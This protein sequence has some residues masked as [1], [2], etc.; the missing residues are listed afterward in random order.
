MALVE[1]FCETPSEELLDGCTK[2]QLL[3]I[4]DH[5]SV[6][7]SDKRLKDTVKSILKAK[8]YEMEILPGKMG[9]VTG[10][11]VSFSP[12]AQS[13]GLSFDQ[14]KELL[15]LQMEHEKLKHRVEVERSEKRRLEV[16]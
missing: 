15:L 6:D 5:Y 1:A 3:K 13:S 4:A 11:G 12:E 9:G 10:A 2:E 7:I 8:L 16:D 14:Q